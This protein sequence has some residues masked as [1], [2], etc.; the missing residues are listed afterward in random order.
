MPKIFKKKSQ[1]A[2]AAAAAGGEEDSQNQDDMTI[3]SG[4]SGWSV[5]GSSVSDRIMGRMKLNLS[6]RSLNNNNPSSTSSASVGS[7]KS[8][9]KMFNAKKTSARN[10]V[11]SASSVDGGRNL[12][13]SSSLRRYRSA[14]L[15]SSVAGVG[16]MEE[17]DS[18]EGKKLPYCTYLVVC[19]AKVNIEG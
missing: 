18:N 15:D 5:G 9:G 1:A 14:G 7:R 11:V 13:K 6:S 8:T 2:A 17:M 12:L 3:T 16:A 10:H 4:I 19:F